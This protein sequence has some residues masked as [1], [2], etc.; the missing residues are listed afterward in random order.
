VKRGTVKWF[1]LAKGFGFITVDG[2][3]PD[4][5]AHVSAI[6]RSGLSTLTS[7]QKVIFEVVTDRK[8]GRPVAAGVQ[9]V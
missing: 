4:V 8:T 3:G 9:V 6:T 1:D 5:F 7:G 2:G